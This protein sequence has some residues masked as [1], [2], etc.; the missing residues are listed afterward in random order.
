MA[1]LR[2]KLLSVVLVAGALAPLAACGS[3]TEARD[4][5]MALDSSGDRP[6]DTFFTDTKEIFCNIDY[7]GQRPDTTVQARI[8]Q[9]SHELSWGAGGPPAAWPAANYILGGAEKAPGIGSQTLSF[10]FTLVPLPGT[11][12]PAGGQLPW[13]VGDYRCEITV[14]G[15][16]Q[17]AAPF[18]VIYPTCPELPVTSNTACFEFVRPGQQCPTQNQAVQCACDAD[19]PLKGLWNCP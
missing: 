15:V 9:I 6:R 3:A 16:A 12:A 14:N 1:S 17:G 8:H 7:V 5:Y 4:V 18:R 11:A 2:S 10:T 19:G 13:P